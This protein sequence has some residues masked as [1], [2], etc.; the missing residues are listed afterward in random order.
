MNIKAV[1][2]DYGQVI[3]LPLDPRAMDALSEMAGVERAKFEPLLWSLRGEYDRGTITVRAYYGKILLSLGIS[4][5]D[6]TI[7]E[8]IEMDLAMWKNTNPGTVEL[9][10]DVKKAGYLLGILS[11]MPH[12]F[13]AWAR[14]NVPALSLPDI[15]MFSCEL[16]L[17]KPEQAI[18]RKLLSLTGL[19]SSE[20]V[21][22]DD[23]H[24]NISSARALGINAFQWEGPE[25]ARQELLSLGVKL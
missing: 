2:F 25:K 14:E 24:E 15:C 8:M 6:K 19:E 22:F 7:G 16:G 4:L 11:N 5:D 20:V 10:E 3:S 9:M 23:Y 12:D 18:F 17:I 1:F 13:V 21:F